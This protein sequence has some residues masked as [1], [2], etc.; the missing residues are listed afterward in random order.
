MKTKRP[1][2]LRKGLFHRQ[3]SGRIRFGLI[4]SQLRGR[5]HRI[6]KNAGWYNRRGEKL[7]AG[8]LSVEDA[9]RIAASLRKG[10]LFIVVSEWALWYFRTYTRRGKRRKA[11][12]DYGR[13]QAPG[14]AAVAD[15]ALYIFAPRKRFVVDR[16][17]SYGRRRV[18]R[19][20]GVKFRILPSAALQALLGLRP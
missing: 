19:I 11:T 5:W 10:E 17:G 7:G 2:P 9:V 1:R 4:D 8:D 20:R 13:E 15:Q 16:H 14:L 3:Y 6:A 12:F 18:E